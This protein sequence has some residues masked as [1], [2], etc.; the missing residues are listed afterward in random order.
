VSTGDR[1]VDAYFAPSVLTAPPAT[2]RAEI[3]QRMAERD[4][5]AIPIVQ[6]THV[7]GIVSLTDLLKFPGSPE[8]PIG[9]VMR[10]EV[11]SIAPGTT[12]R[13]AARTM[14]SHGIHRVLVVENGELVGILATREVMRAIA[15][16]KI[17]TPLNTLMT[18]PVV[19]VD[20]RDPIGF[21]ID[22]LTRS[23]VHGVVV[24][25]RDAPVGVF[26]QVEALRAQKMPAMAPVEDFMSHSLLQ[27]PQDTP[28]HR[29]A[30]FAVAMRA[31]RIVGMDAGRMAGI[32]T[33]MDLIRLVAQS[34]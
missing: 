34:V 29:A 26:T 33:G 7:V 9:E 4:V 8:E 1:L 11:I 6:N 16:D 21:T 23:K 12:L 10:K 18:S 24:T 28:S 5:S 31:R 17:E 25:D 30:A 13:D 2:T 19:S 27:L 32:A 20:V 3:F 15:Q 22:L 14:L